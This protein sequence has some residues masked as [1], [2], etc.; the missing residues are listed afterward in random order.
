MCV[1]GVC[2]GVCVCKPVRV[3]VRVRV[4]PRVCVCTFDELMCVS[5]TPYVT[6][7]YYLQVPSHS[8]WHS[9]TPLL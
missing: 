3:S 6:L 5:S 7:K 1:C 2:L 4:C 8:V 9:E